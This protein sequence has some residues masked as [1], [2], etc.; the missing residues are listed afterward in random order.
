MNGALP[1]SSPGD[2]SGQAGAMAGQAQD[3]L[4]H[5]HGAVVF[6]R[7]LGLPSFARCARQ[8]RRGTV[9]GL[10]NQHAWLAH[11]LLLLNA[12]ATFLAC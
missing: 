2:C 8:G 7:Q 3:I 6:A 5:F 9:R 4:R 12:C 11:Q 1:P 10:A